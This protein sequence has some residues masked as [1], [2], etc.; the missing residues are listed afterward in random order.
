MM[1][2]RIMIL[3]ILLGA[4]LLLWCAC[5]I[6]TPREVEPPATDPG[7][8]Q[9]LDPLDFADILRNSN[10]KERF[11]EL[12]YEDL[13]HEDLAYVGLNEAETFSKDDVLDRLNSIVVTY[14]DIEVD[15]HLEDTTEREPTQPD[16]DELYTLQ[17]RSY[18][19]RADGIKETTIDDE[20]GEIDTVYNVDY[21]GEASFI[22]SYDEATEAWTI[23][24]WRDI[25][26]GT[27]Q[28]SFFHP[29]FS[30]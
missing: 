20:T 15:W 8:R 1:N 18:R 2:N 3:R 28:R 12:D 21:S 29:N 5:G 23:Y 25:P 19:V 17:S 26:A 11:L 30:P 24:Y 13:L 9:E 27:A 16:R 14:D 4:A 6:F 10:S 7:S 22:L